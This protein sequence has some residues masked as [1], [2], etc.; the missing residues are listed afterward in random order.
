MGGLSLTR[1]TILYEFQCLMGVIYKA[2]ISSTYDQVLDQVFD[3]VLN[4][5]LDQVFI[6]QHIC[7]K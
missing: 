1:N 3:Q 5:I 6:K 2:F 7:T 4:Q